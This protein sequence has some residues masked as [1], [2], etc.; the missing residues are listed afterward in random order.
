[1]SVTKEDI[2]KVLNRLRDDEELVEAMVAGMNRKGA[3]G[4]R[5]HVRLSAARHLQS[6]HL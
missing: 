5:Q 4:L 3:R 6:A 2:K 1:M